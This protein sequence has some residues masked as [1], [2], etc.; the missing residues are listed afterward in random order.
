MK[1]SLPDVILRPNEH[2][3]DLQICLDKLKLAS[4]PGNQKKYIFCTFVRNER[5]A[6]LFS[7]EVGTTIGTRI[8]HRFYRCSL[9]FCTG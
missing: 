4:I 5:V 3:T 9:F 1:R 7:R 8:E 6:I 2:E